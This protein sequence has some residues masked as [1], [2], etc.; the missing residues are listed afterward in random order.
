MGHSYEFIEANRLLHIRYDGVL[1]DALLVRGYLEDQDAIKEHRPLA[2]IIDLTRVTKF[3]VKF[4]TNVALAAGR[5]FPDSLRLAFVAP[6][7]VQFGMARM[8]EM[9]ADET[10]GPRVCV[11]RTVEEA[12]T[13]LE[14]APA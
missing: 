6:C 4:E 7:D 9:A 3:G 13:A 11:V 1:T 14:L 8:F 2:V 12:Y 10:L 5:S